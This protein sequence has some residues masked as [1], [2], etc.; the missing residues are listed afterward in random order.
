MQWDDDLRLGYGPM[1]EVHEE[2]VALVAACQDAADAELPALLLKLESHTEAHF[3]EEDRWMRDTDFP[4]ADCHIEQH[5]AV[6]ASI[7]EVRAL[8]AT[9]RVDVA[10]SLLQALE[11]WFP[12][13]ASQL[14]SALAHWMFKR[15]FGGK[16]LLMRRVVR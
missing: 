12:Q 1:D 7:A 6:L 16:P 3:G 9:G 4:P 8:L 10:R 11:E 13:H 14:D 5:Q 15:R 2:F